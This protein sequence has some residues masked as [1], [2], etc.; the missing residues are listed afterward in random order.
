MIRNVVMGRLR[1]TGGQVLPDDRAGLATGLAGIAALTLPGLIANH[2][3]PDA[4]LR[5][6]GWDFAITNDWEDVDAYRAYDVDPVHN[7]YREQ[8]VDACE[9]VARVQFEI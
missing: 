8:I 6:G 1:V 4:G 7:A 2:C 5:T 3:G 9:Q